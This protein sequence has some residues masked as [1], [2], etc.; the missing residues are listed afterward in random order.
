[1]T[2]IASHRRSPLP[3][4][5][6]R[7]L[8]DRTATT[9]LVVITLFALVAAG[10][11]LGLWGRDWAATSGALWQAPSAEHWL[12]T[13]RLGQD[14]LA[15][16]LAATATA[17]E[18]G[19]GVALA[20]TLLGAALGALAGERAGRLTDGIVL[21]LAGVFDAIPFYLFVAAVAVALR[22]WPWAM[23]VAMIAAFWPTT[24]RLVRAEILRLK[25]LEFVEAGRALGL[26]EM[27]LLAR[28][29][30]PN[31]AAVLLVQFS[32]TFIG[33]IKTEVILSFLGLGAGETISWGVMIAEATG[34]V[35]AGQYMNF[36]VA[37]LLLFLLVT[38]VNLLADG[39]QDSLDPR[40]GRGRR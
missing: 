29:L 22:G 37:S 35:L 4:A 14:I 28:H 13:N 31:T 26:P 2:A 38:S 34:E 36:I 39:L 19:L 12:G 17:F 1:M 6:Q 15:R 40:S 24:A 3:P 5:L 32:L 23:H 33:A 21:W 9:G 18:I 30:L 16:A 8:A 7:L 25:E 11:W 10:V 20:A 27:T